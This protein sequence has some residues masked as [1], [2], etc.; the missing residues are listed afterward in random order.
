MSL[1]DYNRD[2][3]VKAL[4]LEGF[5]FTLH[6]VAFEGEQGDAVQSVPAEQGW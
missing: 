3:V 2:V 4:L 6:C 5:G 1:A